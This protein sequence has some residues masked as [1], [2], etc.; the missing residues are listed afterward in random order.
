ML[1]ISALGRQRQMGLRVQGH[2]GL[3]YIASSRIAWLH[4][5]SLSQKIKSTTSTKVPIEIRAFIW[6]EANAS[7]TGTISREMDSMAWWHGIIMIL[8]EVPV[9]GHQCGQGE[10]HQQHSRLA[11]LMLRVWRGD[12]HTCLLVCAPQTGTGVFLSNH[13]NRKQKP[14]GGG[15]WKLF[16]KY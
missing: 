7:V 13:E 12:S 9:P 3:F 16:V 15:S 11:A 2:P 10:A 1:L 14:T 5:E 8:R 6:S 4:R